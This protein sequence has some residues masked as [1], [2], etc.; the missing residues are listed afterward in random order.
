MIKNMYNFI[1]LMTKEINVTLYNW[2]LD[3]AYIS[4][5]AT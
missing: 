4:A 2:F 1:Q 3:N 5:Y